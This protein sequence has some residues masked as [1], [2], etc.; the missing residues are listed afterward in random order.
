MVPQGAHHVPISQFHLQ[1]EMYLRPA[2]CSAVIEGRVRRCSVSFTGLR[3]NQLWAGTDAAVVRE[4]GPCW[5]QGGWPL[6]GG[7]HSNEHRGLGL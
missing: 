4:L 5:G 1:T 3:P 7:F 6:V 2:L